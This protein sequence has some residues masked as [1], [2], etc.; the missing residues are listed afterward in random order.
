[1]SLHKWRIWK[2]IF[3]MHC[4]CNLWIIKMLQKRPKEFLVFMAKVPLLT[5][6]SETGFQSFVLAISHYEIKPDQ[7]A[8]RELMGCHLHERARGLALDFII[9]HSTVCRHFKKISKL[10]VWVPYTLSRKNKEDPISI[11]P[12]LYSRQ[13]NDSYIKN[14]I[15]GKEN[16]FLWQC[17]TQKTVDWQESTLHPT[18][19]FHWREFIVCVWWDKLQSIT[20]CR[21]IQGGTIKLLSQRKQHYSFI[22]KLLLKRLI[23]VTWLCSRADI[24]SM[25][26]PSA[27]I[28]ASI[29]IRNWEHAFSTSAGGSSANTRRMA[30]IKLA[31]VL[32]EVMLV[33]FSTYDQTK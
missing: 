16:C 24:Y 29:R 4:C 15:I 23:Q 21:L 13:R 28:T 17:S 30:A 7:D 11:D 25:Q 10:G 14:I 26:P 9:S 8:F 19:E 2:W 32:W 22:L 33:M 1:M 20:Q 31:L 5:A 3:N 6:K 12:S 27:S 18:P